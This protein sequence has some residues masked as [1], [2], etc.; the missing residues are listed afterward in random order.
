MMGTILASAIIDTVEE[1]LDDTE[2]DRWSEASLLGY[3]NTIQGSIVGFKPNTN[4]ENE[5]V[6]CIA[7]TKQSIPTAGIQLINIVRNMG[8][9]GTVPGRS[10]VKGDLE[11][12]N[13]I[14]RDWHSETAA[15]ATELFFFDDQ[16]PRHFYVYP[17]QPAS[18]FG[19]LEQ[20]YSKAPTDIIIS[21]AITLSDIYEDIIKNGILYLAYARETDSDSLNQS[22]AY[23]ELFATQLGRRDLIEK[24]YEP[25][26]RGDTDGV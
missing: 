14:E 2:N 13:V 26:K 5:A 10:V 25:Q 20:V 21:S 15:V 9:D 18:G 17:P 1:I 16:D 3:L 4:V 11:Q 6:I 24:Q 7:G 12:F 22:R 8:T 23:F 19:Y